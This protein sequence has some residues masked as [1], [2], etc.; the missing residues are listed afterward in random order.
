MD[1]LFQISLHMRTPSGFETFGK[2]ELGSDREQALAIFSQLKGTPEIAQNSILCMD[3]SEIR[4]GIPLP[5]E[6]MHC[7]LDELACNTKIITRE[8]FKN[9]GI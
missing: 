2:F 1:S 5:I 9:L 6:I 7:R 8:V 3:F 4:D